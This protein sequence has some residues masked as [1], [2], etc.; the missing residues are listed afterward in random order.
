MRGQELFL[1]NSEDIVLARLAHT[2][3]GVLFFGEVITEGLSHDTCF[4]T[5]HAATPSDG[6]GAR[7]PSEARK[8]E[9]DSRSF[10]CRF[11]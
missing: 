6:K 4:S 3:D 8:E 7:L 10:L 5:G 1:G 9:F 2:R 11:H